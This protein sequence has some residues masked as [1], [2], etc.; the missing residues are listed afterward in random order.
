MNSQGLGVTFIAGI[1]GGSILA[2]LNLLR[3][4]TFEKSW[5]LYSVCAYF[6]M[7]WLVALATVPHLFSIY[8]QVSMRTAFICAACGLGW[9]LAVVLFGISVKLV[10]L[11]LASAIIYGSSIAVGSLAPMLI[12]Y[13]RRMF[14][15][16]GLLLVLADA[17]VIAGVLLCTM[18]GKKRDSALETSQKS[19]DGAELSSDRGDFTKGIVSSILAAFLSSLFN[20]ALAY[21]D[22]F[23]RLAV[24]A[25][26][27]PLNAA[28]A[29]WAFTVT[30]G[31]IPNVLVSIITFTR[32]QSWGELPKGP[33]LHWIWPPIMGLTW[34]G[35]T[36]L[37]GMGATLLGK[38]GPVIGWPVYMSMMI[39]TG[40][41]WGWIVGEWKNAP[42]RALH[43]LN[44]GIIVQLVSIGALGRVS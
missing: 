7:P 31:Y 19:R 22:E 39:I 35:G 9:G 11:S 1:L 15:K 16:Q 38:L 24:A 6:I 32:N 10:G 36:A 43:F 26:S 44:A 37:Y 4:W 27:S 8:P 30:F 14:S 5:A 41:F 21:G 12:S 13:P 33:P 28:N 3:S 20:I 29:Q 42:R 17:G 25:G 18:A 40:V 23:N 2:P 34:I